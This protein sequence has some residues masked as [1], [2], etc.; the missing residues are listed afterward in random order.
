MGTRGTGSTWSN[1]WDMMGTKSTGSKMEQ[2][3]TRW[4]RMSTW[5]GS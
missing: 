4:D 2:W 5:M 3:S 1:K